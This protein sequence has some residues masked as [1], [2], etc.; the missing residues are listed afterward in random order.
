MALPAGQR[1]SDGVV[2]HRRTIVV[3][4]GERGFNLLAAEIDSL[5]KIN[6]QP[7]L[8][9]LESFYLEIACVHLAFII[10]RLDG[11]SV[12]AYGGVAI[13]FHLTVERAEIGEPDLFPSNQ[14]SP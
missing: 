5:R 14:A 8:L 12:A 2:C 11:N 3:A 9:Q 6:G 7:H 4:R 13:Q 1:V 10:R